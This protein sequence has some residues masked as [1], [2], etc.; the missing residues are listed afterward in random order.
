MLMFAFDYAAG[1]RW[2]TLRVNRVEKLLSDVQILSLDLMKHGLELPRVG[3][4]VPLSSPL[5]SLAWGSL[6]MASGKS[7]VCHELSQPCKPTAPLQHVDT[8]I[9]TYV[10][11][12]FDHRT[13]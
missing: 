7:K 1:L 11:W 4:S 2:L 9:S 8:Y 13:K 5:L 10:I 6:G 3:T 12:L